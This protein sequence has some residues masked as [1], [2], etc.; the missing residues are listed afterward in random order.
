LASQSTVQGVPMV[1]AMVGKV[2]SEPVEEVLR[3]TPE[4]AGVGGSGLAMVV[5][6]MRGPG[7]SAIARV[8]SRGEERILHLTLSNRSVLSI[9][10]PRAGTVNVP[11]AGPASA[12][13]GSGR[14]YA[15][16]FDGDRRWVPVRPPALSTKW[17]AR[18]G[19]ANGRYEA[20]ERS[21]ADRDEGLRQALAEH[22]EIPVPGRKARLRQWVGGLLLL[23]EVVTAEFAAELSEAVYR[24]I[25]AL[26]V[27]PDTDQPRWWSF[28][29]S[30]RPLPLKPEDLP[31]EARAALAEL[32]G[33][34]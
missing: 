23:G 13:A 25:I 29:P 5:R 16:V 28:Q 11:V 9:S 21:Q 24:D 32:G 8:V 27:G 10:D 7:S 34:G 31:P 15:V 22:V 33:P 2:V 19:W 30:G 17:R 26:A 1:T 14:W 3:R 6:A 12:G 20:A 4:F 18:T